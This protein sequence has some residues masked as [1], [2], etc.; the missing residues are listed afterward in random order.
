MSSGKAPIT[1]LET[2][3]VGS[4]ADTMAAHGFMSLPVGSARGMIFFLFA[5]RKAIII[6]FFFSFLLQVVGEDHQRLVGII[7]V[8]DIITGLLGAVQE[9]ELSKAAPMYLLQKISPVRPA[10]TLPCGAPLTQLIEYFATGTQHVFLVDEENRIKAVATQSAA[11]RFLA[12][13]LSLWQVGRKPLTALGF[14]GTNCISCKSSQTVLEGL[15]TI[16]GHQLTGVPVVDAKN[17]IIANLSA[18]DFLGISPVQTDLLHMDIP[19]FLAQVSPRSL[20]PETA[21]ADMTLFHAGNQ[22]KK[23]KKK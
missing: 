9:A 19:A 14:N 12:P 4:V 17:H 3:T 7:S 18:R 6:S 20:H 13:F 2:A 16:A 11:A 22:K 21:S 8:W 23:R 10:P 1:V 5:F 15:Q